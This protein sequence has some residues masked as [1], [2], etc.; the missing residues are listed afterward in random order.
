MHI[1]WIKSALLS[2]RGTQILACDS[3]S[4]SITWTNMTLTHIFGIYFFKIFPVI[5]SD[6]MITFLTI[7]R[8]SSKFWAK[9]VV[10]ETNR[11]WNPL[12][13]AVV[14]FGNAIEKHIL[15]LYLLCG[16]FCGSIHWRLDYWYCLKFLTVPTLWHHN[17]IV[18]I[19]KDSIYFW[20]LQEIWTEDNFK[21]QIR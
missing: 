15:H 5:V 2:P 19:P 6:F 14:D 12:P 21:P 17:K 3:C 11:S 7:F 8:V 16:I 20:N 9:S 18:Q 4:Y 1:N 13:K 10:C